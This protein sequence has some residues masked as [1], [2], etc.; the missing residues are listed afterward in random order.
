MQVLTQVAQQR[1]KA[2]LPPVSR[3]LGLRLPP[4]EDCLIAPDYQLRPSRT[5]PPPP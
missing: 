4:E 5:L 2:A 1:N 3:K